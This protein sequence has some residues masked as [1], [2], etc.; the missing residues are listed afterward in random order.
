LI[1]AR[2][3]VTD[4]MSALVQ[5]QTNHR[6]LKSDFVRY[7]RPIA[8]K[9]GRGWIWARTFRHSFDHFVSAGENC[10]RNGE[11][12]RHTAGIVDQTERACSE[13][14]R[15]CR[16]YIH[17]SLPVAGVHSPSAVRHASVPTNSSLTAD[18]RHC[19]VCAAQNG[20]LSKGATK[21]G[22]LGHTG[23]GSKGASTVKE[24]IGN[25]AQTECPLWVKSGQTVPD[26][27]LT[28]STIVRKR[29]KWCVAANDAKCQ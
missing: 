29:T 16:A 7:C 19:C 25:P 3:T 8:D 6:G 28:L 9:P 24:Q 14:L 1:A 22:P 12:L 2:H 17:I 10:W 18:D 20:S 26:R 23:G 15:G 21:K 11:S 13:S 5:K 27:N 4:L